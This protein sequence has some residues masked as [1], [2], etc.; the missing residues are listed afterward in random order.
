MGKE[1]IVG[2][3]ML[4]V[5]NALNDLHNNL[6][7]HNDIKPANILSNKYGEIKLSDFG[8]VLKMDDKYSYLTKINGTERY[9]SPEKVSTK[10]NTK[11]DIWSVGISAFELLFGERKK[12]N[13]D[14]DI[15]IPLLTPKK[16]KLSANCCDFINECLIYDDKERPSA[17]QLLKHKWFTQ[18]I[19]PIPLKQK[20]PWLV[21]VDDKNVKN[22]KNEEKQ[23]KNDN[24]DLLFMITALIIHYSQQNVNLENV[25]IDCLYRK[26]SH[27]KG[28]TDYERI[29]NMAKYAL[30]S[31]EMVIERIRGTVAYIKSQLNKA[32]V[33]RIH[34]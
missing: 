1:L 14:T 7:V 22:G 30:C 29:N 19:K 3:I 17:Q 15:N 10:Y 2:H 27:N 33:Y 24:G 34:G 9:R 18:N 26:K 32:D 25:G 6:Y 13:D 8:T 31:K 23:N 12:S 21:E 16:Y 20:W 28:D 5:L 4:N 11:S